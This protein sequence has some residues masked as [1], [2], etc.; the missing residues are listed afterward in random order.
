CTEIWALADCVS[1]PVCGYRYVGLPYDTN[2]YSP[3][4]TFG[5]GVKADVVGTHTGIRG[6]SSPNVEYVAS[7]Q[8]QYDITTH[9]GH[10]EVTFSEPGGDFGYLALEHMTL[11]C[12]R[13]NNLASLPALWDFYNVWPEE[14]MEMY[15]APAGL[16]VWDV[17]IP[18]TPVSLG[19]GHV[20]GA[21][22][23]RIVPNPNNRQSSKIA[24]FVPSALIPEPEVEGEVS[25]QNLHAMPSVD[26]LIVAADNFRAEAERLA[27]AH[28]AMQGLE[29]AV[30]TQD[31]VFNEFSSGAY[32][33]N[34]LRRMVN[35]LATRG[36]RPLRHLLLMGMGQPR[37]LSRGEKLDPFRVVSIQ[38][39]YI[40]EDRYNSKN[41]TG[42]I[43]YGIITDKHSE[44]VTIPNIPVTVNVGRA[45][46][47]TPAEAAD[48]V[49]KCIA[50]LQ[51][52]TMAGRCDEAMVI[53]CLGDDYAH[54]DAV[55]SVGNLLSEAN[56]LTTVHN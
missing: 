36:D 39:E 26:M 25:A 3:Q 23:A 41:H 28:R 10:L 52:P 14:I 7:G 46:L 42:D 9:P 48:F 35:M 17:T 4:I 1:K 21:G 15:G 18:R 38:S 40:D 27:E 31:E 51:D 5:Q 29:V 49:D 37:G 44:R 54:M 30:V 22:T 11:R 50:Y 19:I 24:A 2:R 8:N 34:G 6:T 16:V 13:S 56:P 32:H 20:D 43:Y 47:K 53:G 45:L 12:E 33:P 55:I